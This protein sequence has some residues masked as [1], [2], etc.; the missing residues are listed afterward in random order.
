MQR[1]RLSRPSCVCASECERVASASGAPGAT[2][3]RRGAAH[4]VVK[5]GGRARCSTC[6]HP[7]PHYVKPV[8]RVRRAY[9]RAPSAR[10]RHRPVPLCQACSQGETREGAARR[11]RIPRTR[12]SP[13]VTREFRVRRTKNFRFGVVF[14]VARANRRRP[15][16][17][18]CADVLLCAQRFMGAKASPTHSRRLPRRSRGARKLCQPSARQLPST[19]VRAPCHRRSE[20]VTDRR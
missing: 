20:Y 10:P 5:E 17:P 14:L 3:K 11:P 8:A 1:Q 7:L 6:E 13:Y 16:S 12:L 15:P 4:N 2:P 19:T 9:E 18:L